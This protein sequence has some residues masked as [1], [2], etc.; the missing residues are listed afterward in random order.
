[1]SVTACDVS[2]TRLRSQNPTQTFQNSDKNSLQRVVRTLSA[3]RSAMP[4]NDSPPSAK[5]NDRPVSC[6]VG[7]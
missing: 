7:T 2:L 1:M 5:N 6:R 3:A 4:R